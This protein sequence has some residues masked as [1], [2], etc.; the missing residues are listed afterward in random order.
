MGQ[1]VGTLIGQVSFPASPYVARLIGEQLLAQGELAIGSRWAEW[2]ESCARSSGDQTMR[3]TSANL[4]ALIDFA[5]GNLGSAIERAEE[6]LDG[7]DQPTMV[8]SL[9]ILTVLH[10][11]R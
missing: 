11:T 10:S 3:A 5:L 2:L 9:A 4:L 1:L 8:H 7:G 6:V